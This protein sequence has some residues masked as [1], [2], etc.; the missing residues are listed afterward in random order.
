MTELVNLI[1]AQ[2]NDRANAQTIKPRQA[3]DQT[4]LTLS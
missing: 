4:L 3:A 2:R 1:T